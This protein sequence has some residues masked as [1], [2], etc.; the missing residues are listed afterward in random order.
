MITKKYLGLFVLLFLLANCKKAKEDGHTEMSDIDFRISN[1]YQ[2][3]SDRAHSP[4]LRLQNLNKGYQLLAQSKSPELVA[5]VL[6]LKSYLHGKNKDYDSAIVI[7]K[8]LYKQ[9][10]V[11]QDY[12]ITAKS[13]FKLGG[14]FKS[15]KQLDSAYYYYNESNQFYLILKDSIGLGKNYLNM[16]N[17][18]TRIGDYSG[19]DELAVEGLKFLS[20]SNRNVT[21]ASLENCL[22]IGA[23]HREDYEEALMRYRRAVHKTPKRYNKLVYQNNIGNVFVKQKNYQEAIALFETIVND[24]LTWTDKTLGAKVKDNLTYAKWLQTGDRRLETDFLEALDIRIEEDDQFGQMASFNHLS[25]FYKAYNLE[26]SKAWAQKMYTQAKKVNSVDTQ[27]Q[28][29]KKLMALNEEDT[30]FVRFTKRYVMLTDSITEAKY[31]NTNRFAKIRFESEKRKAEI[32]ELKAINVERQLSLER[33]EIKLIIILLL[34]GVLVVVG[35]LIYKNNKIKYH[36]ATMTQVYETETKISKRIHDEIANDVYNT[37]SKLQSNAAIDP[38][39]II[40]DLDYIYNRA[41]DI[42][43]EHGSIDFKI[44]FENILND[45]FL[46]FETDRV[47]I[48]TKGLHKMDWAQVSELKKATIYRILQELLVN[49]KKHSEASMVVL[50]FERFRK[51]MH[52]S[53]SDNGKGCAVKKKNGLL[54][55]ENRII[56]FD[57]TINFISEKN[58]GFK[59]HIEI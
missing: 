30:N 7:S 51:K 4:S 25:D 8:K 2:L 19:S 39:F 46:N 23:K 33:A 43:K 35:I 41:R 49:M 50:V 12:N 56:S 14:Y 16:A 31:K 5:R 53:Y 42:S 22:A 48:I 34:V 37:M 59:A 27:V 28:A 24:S 29:L 17:I 58:K 52:I 9:G 21:I 40:D 18:L 36:K 44:E 1:S 15:K 57:G 55:V 54:N 10:L 6:D 38:E 47:R 26:K 3:A 13:C 20:N 45:L 11:K 32:S